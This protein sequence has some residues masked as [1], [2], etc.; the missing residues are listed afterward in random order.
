MHFTQIMVQAKKSCLC[1]PLKGLI[2]RLAD[3]YSD[4]FLVRNE[5]HFQI[6][7]FEDGTPFEPDFVLFLREKNG[8]TLTYQLFI[9]PKGKHLQAHDQWKEC[10]LKKILEKSQNV[11]LEFTSPSSNQGYRLIGV[12]FY[13]NQNENEFKTTLH[14]VLGIN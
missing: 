8:N 7:N 4:I 6:Y 5:R 3:K 9:E 1:G 11:P 10:F 14:D 2:D 13:N 12:P